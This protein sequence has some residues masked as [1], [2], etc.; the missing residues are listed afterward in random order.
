MIVETKFIRHIAQKDCK[1]TYNGTNLVEM[2]R[3]KL[4]PIARSL[5]I[6]GEMSKNDLLIKLVAKLNA[7]ES[8]DEIT[9]N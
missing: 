6:S 7:L 2:R 9:E 3:A 1:Y 4:Y 8:A 5:D